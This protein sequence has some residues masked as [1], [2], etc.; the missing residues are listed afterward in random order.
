MQDYFLDF[1]VDPSS[2]A[3][4]GWP[5]YTSQS[6]GGK[7][8]QFGADGQVVQSVDGDSVEGACHVPGVVYNTTP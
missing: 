5:E 3:Q 6:G 8:A 4:N 2:L 7:I 1:I